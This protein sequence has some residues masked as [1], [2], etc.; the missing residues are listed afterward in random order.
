MTDKIVVLNTCS[1]REEAERVARQLVEQ[2]LAACV[3]IVGGVRSV[4]H[5]QGKLEDSEEVLLVIKSR[6][7]LFAE[8]QAAL[9]RAHSY[10]VPEVLAL[11]VVEGSE[12]YLGWLDRELKPSG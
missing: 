11:A 2:R 8:L 6:R 4:Y 12:A 5:W 1:S 7:E 3:S 9:G 10:E